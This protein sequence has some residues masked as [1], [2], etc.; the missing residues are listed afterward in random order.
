M[1][2][3]E[4]ILASTEMNQR[5]EGPYSK[6]WDGSDVTRV[7]QQPTEEL[8]RTKEYTKADYRLRAK[9]QTSCLLRSTD[10]H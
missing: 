3:D 7:K 9:S 1:D 6:Y 5:T 2:P 10:H 8:Q 4:T